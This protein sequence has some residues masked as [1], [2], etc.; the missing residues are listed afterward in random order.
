MRQRTEKIYIMYLG[1]FITLAGIIEAFLSIIGQEIT[2]PL[3]IATGSMWNLWKGL[4]LFFSGSFIVVGSMKFSRINGVGKTV[5]GSIMLWI[6]AGA[7]IFARITGSI[8]GKNTWFNSL[9]GFLS[10]YGPPY[11]LEIWLLPLSLVLILIIN[12][13]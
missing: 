1:I 2:T 8:P 4:I 12:K 6:V 13:R 7:N 11:E 5:I 3:L 10:S 9:G